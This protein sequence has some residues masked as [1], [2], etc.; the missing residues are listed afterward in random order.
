MGIYLEF[1]KTNS[2]PNTSQ[3]APFPKSFSGENAPNPPPPRKVQHVVSRPA[4]F[5]KIWK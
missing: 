3:I 1:V 2:D 4:I 5:L